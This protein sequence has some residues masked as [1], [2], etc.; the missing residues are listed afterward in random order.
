MVNQQIDKE[1]RILIHA[2]S[3]H[4]KTVV[5]D[6]ICSKIFSSMQGFHIFHSCVAR[7]T[8]IIIT[9]IGMAWSA[10]GCISYGKI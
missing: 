2:S 8:E 5:R 9:K 7:T 4:N 1:I 3:C 6:K 10:M